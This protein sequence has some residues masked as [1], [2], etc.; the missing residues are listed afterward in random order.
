MVTALIRYFEIRPIGFSKTTIYSKMYKLKMLLQG[1]L[2]LVEMAT[3]ALYF[4]QPSLDDDFYFVYEARGYSFVLILDI[5][6]WAIGAALLN[7]EYQKRLSEAFY[8]HWFFWSMMLIN[9][10]VFLIL[11]FTQH[12]SACQSIDLVALVHR[13]CQLHLS[14]LHPR[15]LLDDALHQAPH[16]RQP[17]TR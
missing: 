8:T 7:Y 15:P 12:V 9:D 1:V 2:S 17:K 4:V 13:L 3:I 11:N 10:V 6:A 16:F 5:F 14:K